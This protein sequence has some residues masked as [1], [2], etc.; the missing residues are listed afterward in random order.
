MRRFWV[1]LRARATMLEIVGYREH[2]FADTVLDN[3]QRS[4]F[5]TCFGF[6]SLIQGCVLLLLKLGVCCKSLI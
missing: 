4:Y 5:V 1:G 3:Q 6:V 2:V